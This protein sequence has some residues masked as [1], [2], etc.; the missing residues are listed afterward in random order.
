MA[1]TTSA[2]VQGVLVDNWDGKTRLNPFIDAATLVVTR[3]LACATAKG[4]TLS[5]DELEMIERWLAA[6]FYAQQDRPYQSK[7]TKG[8][9]ASFQGQT[10]MRLESTYFGQTALTID[11]SGCLEALNNRQVARGFWL[12]RAPSE[13]T[14]YEDR[15]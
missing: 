9:S 13:Q 5:S 4:Y 12:G 1:R 7:S 15:D 8:A 6:H 10:G 3:V 14:N 2:L 11:T